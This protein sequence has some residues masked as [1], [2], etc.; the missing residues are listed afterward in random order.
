M[1]IIR[2]D[3]L[4]PW[5]NLAA[6]E[7]LL[8]NSGEDVFMLWRNSPSVIIG[9]N[10]N[11]F[12]EIDQGYAENHGI[13]I[14]RRLT[15]GGA[16]FHDPGNVNFTFIARAPEEPVIDFATFT[17]PIIRVLSGL[18][19]KA[20]LSGRNDIM[21]DGCKISGNAQCVYRR[22]DGERM[23]LH[24]GTLLYDADMSALVGVLRVNDDKL[25]SKGIK[26]VA[27]RVSNIKS[28]GGLE[29]T[30]VEFTEYI[31]AEA[32]RRFGAVSAP[33]TEE[34]KKEIEKLALDK[35][36][37]W[38]W[39]YGKSPEICEMRRRR[40]PWGTLEIGYKVDHGVVAQCTVSGDFFGTEDVSVLEGALVGARFSSEDVAQALSKINVGEIIA[41]GRAEDILSLLF[42]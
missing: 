28:L 1:R 21:A 8:E 36:S 20:E 27:S 34:E 6:E 41:D 14:V 16:V 18:G 24:H 29:M 5:F 30:S 32:E 23:L 38:E 7:Y 26:S 2:N 40:F 31:L 13:K 22:S 15:G 10:Q 25:R 42:E 19:I 35:Y 12:A 9:K 39:N 4:Q 11:A 3:S 33:L 37:T 17:E